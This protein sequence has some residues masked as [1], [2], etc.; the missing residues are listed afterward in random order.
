MNKYQT[1]KWVW[2]PPF[3]DCF[4]GTVKQ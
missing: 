4:W 1:I 2:I 3:W